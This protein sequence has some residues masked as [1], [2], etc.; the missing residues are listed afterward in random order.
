MILLYH[1]FA[2]FCSVLTQIKLLF[3]S[4]LF[5]MINNTPGERSDQILN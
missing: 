1:D 4:D 5:N 2:L 3:Y